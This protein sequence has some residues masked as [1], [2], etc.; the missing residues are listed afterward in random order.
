MRILAEYGDG[1][2]ARVCV[3]Q[4]RE[5]N[6]RSIV[7]FV[8]S[9]QPPLPRERKWVLIVST[10][11]GCPIGCK[12][13]DAGGDFAGMLTS[14]E[15]L[16]QIDALVLRR[17]PD[18]RV[19]VSKFKI[20]FSRMG[21]PSLN[22]SVL[23]AMEAIPAIY[24]APGLLVSLSTIA[25][26]QSRGFFEDLARIKERLYPEGRFQ[27]QFSIHSTD[28]E[29]RRELIP[30]RTWTFEQMAAYGERF[31]D[32]ER[33]DRKVVLNFA[34]AVGYD[35]EASV[36]AANFDPDKFIIKLTPLN[37]TLRA[38]SGGLKSVIEPGSPGTW[39]PMASD[40]AREGYDVILSIGET[41]ENRIGSNCGQLI[42][43]ALRE[44]DR[45]KNAYDLDR[46]RTM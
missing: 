23:R 1:E 32:L 3:A 4:V 5:E 10:M 45:L 20:Q 9:V 6:P 29:K 30:T 17:H 13:C 46:Y 24:D 26:V 11:F 25:P 7:E 15:I 39:E 33:G 8:E 31:C 44:N 18:R 35:V 27:L 42:Q 2:L 28:Q 21:E 12:M 36:I 22:P 37:P 43:R 16:A 19:P 41:E 38:T 14:D 40:F 34:P